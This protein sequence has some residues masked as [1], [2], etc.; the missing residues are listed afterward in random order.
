MRAQL[1]LPLHLHLHTP[2]V[3]VR[4]HPQLKKLKNTQCLQTR[5][6]SQTRVCRDLPL[7]R[8][9]RQHDPTSTAVVAASRT[10]RYADLLRDVVSQ[11]QSPSLSLSH[12][13]GERGGSL[14][15]RRVAFLMENNY[16]YVG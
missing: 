4:V 3:Q 12:G 11:S 16:D 13:G 8:A 10:F 5:Y 1:H 14:K 2:R 15:G 6:L 9:L 7:F